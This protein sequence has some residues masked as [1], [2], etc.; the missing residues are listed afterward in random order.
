MVFLQRERM[1]GREGRKET[2]K[3]GRKEEE[4]EIRKEKERTK[5]GRKTTDRLKEDS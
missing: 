4:R 2:N 3:E 5:E 1:D